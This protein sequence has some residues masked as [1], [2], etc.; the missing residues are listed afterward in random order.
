[1]NTFLIC[2]SIYILWTVI[3]IVFFWNIMGQ[4]FRKSRWYDLPLMLPVMPIAYVIGWLDK[5]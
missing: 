4:K 2:L 5:K 1:M 3:G